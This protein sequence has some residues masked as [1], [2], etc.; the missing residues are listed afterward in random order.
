M[1][2]H[3]S[4]A[5]TV[6]KHHNTQHSNIYIPW[7]FPG[8][9]LKRIIFHLW[10]CLLSVPDSPL[11]QIKSINS[12]LIQPIKSKLTTHRGFSCFTL[13]SY[14][15]M[16]HMGPGSLSHCFPRW[17]WTGSRASW[18]E[19]WKR[20]DVRRSDKSRTLSQSWRELWNEDKS[21]QDGLYN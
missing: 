19:R 15:H 8:D 2:L 18:S 21:T 9:S 10:L 16:S 4:L 1:I 7:E 13:S 20:W 6:A 3:I 14:H 5:V 11:K 12:Y 17:T